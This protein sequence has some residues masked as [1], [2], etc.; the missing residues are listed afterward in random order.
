MPIKSIEDKISYLINDSQYTKAL[1]VLNSEWSELTNSQYKELKYGILS[2]WKASLKDRA[3]SIISDISGT[4]DSLHIYGYKECISELTKYCDDSSGAFKD[5]LR[6]LDGAFNNKLAL[7]IK[8][9]LS[10]ID[11]CDSFYEFIA[12]SHTNYRE[13][14]RFTFREINNLIRNKVS[15]LITIGRYSDALL[16]ENKLNTLECYRSK[17]FIT[18]L[19][20]DII[21]SI[22]AAIEKASTFVEI[23]KIKKLIFDCKPNLQI[24]EFSDLDRKIE[25]RRNILSKKGQD[26]IDKLAESCNKKDLKDAKKVLSQIIDFYGA[27]CEPSKQKVRDLEIEL[28]E[29]KK[30]TDFENALNAIYT[31]ISQCDLTDIDEKIYAIKNNHLCTSKEL[32][33]INRLVREAQKKIEYE[34]TLHSPQQLSLLEKPFNVPK[35]VDS[36]EDA[37]PLVIIDENIKW[38][39]IGVFDGMGGAGGSKYTNTLTN[40]EHTSA[41]WASRI[42]RKC[43]ETLIVSRPIGMNPE[44]YIDSNLHK[45]INISL[46][47]E[48]KKFKGVSTIKSKMIRR[49]PTTMA[50]AYYFIYE[51][52]IRICCYW[53]G[54]SR[55]YLLGEKSIYFL[56]KDDS[57]TDDPFAPENLDLAMNNT[58]CQ[59]TSDSFR[60]NKSTI[61]LPIT[62]FP[63]EL[64]ACTDGCFGYY[65]NPILFERLLRNS[66]KEA[67]NWNEIMPNIQQ[68]IIDN[69]QQDDF[70]MAII[71]F[72]RCSFD[73]YKKI[74]TSKLSGGLM[75]NFIIW[76]TEYVD[77]EKKLKD[78][79]Q[80]TNNE[81]AAK[82]EQEPKEKINQFR[83]DYEQIQKAVENLIEISAR[84]GI[85]ADNSDFDILTAWEHNLSEL[86]ERQEVIQKEITTLGQILKDQKEALETHQI[87]GIDENNTWYGRY[88]D[89][90]NVYYL[91]PNG[92]I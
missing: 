89:S 32:D 9:E 47:E 52:N 1:E 40:E 56:T 81:I 57:N 86:N 13:A 82:R 63:L 36:G 28:E 26:I 7:I 19:H 74:M 92:E 60:I 6:Q 69:I 85:K 44:E 17:E 80:W 79:I 46:D 54:D 18:G 12:Y 53:A 62:E 29:E 65:K 37:D 91:T 58:I 87:T 73:E 72:G 34:K 33:N 25:N 43:V 88:R 70:S 14:F 35:K 27:E 15:N 16:L 42:V 2:K 76:Y 66:I 10:R 24:R 90:G 23:E 75:S 51:D 41:Y 11:N 59:D 83:A 45:A 55:I 48:I 38:G 4:T 84:Q 77:K 31:L 22:S 50:L 21:F 71:T 49:L 78:Q 5:E 64:V 39:L 67:H 3:L 8:E 68:G 61:T 30:K 20:N